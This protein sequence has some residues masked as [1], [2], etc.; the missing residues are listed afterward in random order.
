MLAI[1]R[2]GSQST[3]GD[4]IMKDMIA[5][6][7]LYGIADLFDDMFK[8]VF[9]ERKPAGMMKTDIKE[10]DKQIEFDIDM[11]GYAK[12]QI[13]VT[14]EKGYLQVSAKKEEH[15]SEDDK[16]NGYVRR[17]RSFAC[18]RTYYVG[19]KIKEEDIKAKYENGVLSLVVPKE[20][21]KLQPEHKIK[22][23]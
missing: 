21:P 19:D 17:E 16:N 8:P 5:K 11:P 2:K 7:D 13:N 23:D 14:F 22:I 15:H 10:N 12:D 6:D 1:T 9:F 18:S 3:K 20:L 4:F